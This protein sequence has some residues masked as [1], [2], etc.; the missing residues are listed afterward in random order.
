MMRKN[1]AF[2]Q[3]LM[4]REHNLHNLL[5]FQVACLAHLQRGA[6]HQSLMKRKKKTCLIKILMMNHLNYPRKKEFWQMQKMEKEKM[7]LKTHLEANKM[8]S[9]ATIRLVLTLMALIKLKRQ[10]N[11]QRMEKKNDQWRKYWLISVSNTQRWSTSQELI[12]Q[13]IL[14]LV[15]TRSILLSL[16]HFNLLLQTFYSS[17][18]FGCLPQHQMSTT[19][20][21]GELSPC[22]TQNFKSMKESSNFPWLTETQ[23]ST[24]T[25]S[26]I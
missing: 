21:H 25:S 26:K 13:K 6:K 19:S 18:F 11:F 12:S 5:L 16:I 2:L 1:N 22:W 4:L 9:S 23:T 3:D 24:W 8:L 14:T 7:V 20:S 10:K 15:V 17:N